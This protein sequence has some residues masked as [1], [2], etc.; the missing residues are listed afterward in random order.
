MNQFFFKR[1][2]CLKKQNYKQKFQKRCWKK[3]I[4]FLQIIFL[5]E[6][7]HFPLIQT[8]IYFQVHLS[9]N[10]KEKEKTLMCF[11]WLIIIFQRSLPLLELPSMHSPNSMVDS[12]SAT[13][14]KFVIKSKQNVP[15]LQNGF[16]RWIIEYQEQYRVYTLSCYC[17]QKKNFNS[18]K[19]ICSD[20]GKF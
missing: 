17:L 10:S 15:L 8:K 1:D 4:F 11:C 18:D 9:E 12:W 7:M 20:F 16:M 19:K 2:R 13:K 14:K 5:P 3:K 6:D